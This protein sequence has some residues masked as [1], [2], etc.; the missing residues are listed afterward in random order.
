MVE[1]LTLE[2]A[3]NA[4]TD[5]PVACVQMGQQLTEQYVEELVI[6]QEACTD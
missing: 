2:A 3:P 1:Q 5:A 4:L 6:L